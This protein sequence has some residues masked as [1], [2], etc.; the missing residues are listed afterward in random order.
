MYYVRNDFRTKPCEEER[1]M[2]SN[3]CVDFSEVMRLWKQQ[4][5]VGA[6]TVA[7]AADIL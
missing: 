1:Y 7:A 5:P 3:Y 2:D 4:N 6:A